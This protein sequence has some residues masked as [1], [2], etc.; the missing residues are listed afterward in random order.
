MAVKKDAIAKVMDKVVSLDKDLKA[1]VEGLGETLTKTFNEKTKLL[2]EI[3][4][5]I[6]DMKKNKHLQQVDIGNI[7]LYE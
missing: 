5:D 4:D 3:S 6:A 7:S 1:K 2:N